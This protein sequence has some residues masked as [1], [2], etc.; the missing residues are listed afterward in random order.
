MAIM[1]GQ[2]PRLTAV[3]ILL[4]PLVVQAENRNFGDWT[5]GVND[6]GNPYAVTANDS[7]SILG[8][9]CLM[10][11]DKCVYLL[12][13]PLRCE[14][15]SSYPTL[16]N[17]TVG[18]FANTLLCSGNKTLD[19]YSYFFDNYD[20]VE[21]TVLVADRVAVALPISGDNFR[22]AHFSLNGS[23]KALVLLEAIVQEM[24]QKN[25]PDRTEPAGVTGDQ[26]L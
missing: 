25:V 8:K 24:R 4:L 20:L 23:S 18:A 2:R 5:V 12:G 17:S 26:E 21:K 9:V 11:L 1:M 15:G 14:A 7:G 16:I 13:V 6:E 10:N 22:V 19:H 3:L